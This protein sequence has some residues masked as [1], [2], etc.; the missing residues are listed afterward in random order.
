M[1]PMNKTAPVFGV[2][3]LLAAVVGLVGLTFDSVADEKKVAIH[4]VK[5]T[6][7]G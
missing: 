4:V 7:G 6:G 5:A 3:V 2:Q 1:K